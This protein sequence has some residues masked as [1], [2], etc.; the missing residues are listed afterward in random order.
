M[1]W[2]G[3]RAYERMSCLWDQ[4]LDSTPLENPAE[5]NQPLN[6]DPS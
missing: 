4:V 6:W 2:V 5:L 1:Q 3:I